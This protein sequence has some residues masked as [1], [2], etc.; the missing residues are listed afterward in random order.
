MQTLIVNNRKYQVENGLIY[1]LSPRGDA[2]RNRMQLVKPEKCPH[3]YAA[4]MQ[5][6]ETILN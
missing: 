6:L 3:E 1:R 5:K 2:R 4:V